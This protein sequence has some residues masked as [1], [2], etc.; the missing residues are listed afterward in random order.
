ML[1][2]FT[3]G[4][5]RTFLEPQTLSLVAANIVSQDRA[6]DDDNVNTAHGEFGVL[7]SA[8][9]YGANASGKSRSEAHV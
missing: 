7:K 2:T 3:V 4:N 8:G 5:F 1:M 6:L 9:V